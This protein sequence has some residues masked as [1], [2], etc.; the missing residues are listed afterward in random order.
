MVL[1]FFW[2]SCLNPKLFSGVNVTSVVKDGDSNSLSALQKQ[3]PGI[4]EILDFNHIIKNIPKHVNAARKEGAKGLQGRQSQI[5]A[6]VSRV[7]RMVH[8][9]EAADPAKF[10]IQIRSRILKHCGYVCAL[11]LTGDHKLC[12]VPGVGDAAPGGL[13]EQV[14]WTC[15]FAGGAGPAPESRKKK[16]Q[17]LR[18][19]KSVGFVVNYFEQ[20]ASKPS[21]LSG[22]KHM[23]YVKSLER[24]K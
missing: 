23:Y 14:D 9:S 11:H 13:L 5:Q 16:D 19:A 1:N 6:Q 18:C 20:L 4:V 3:F 15:P 22:G 12:P 21:V 2:A 17:P 8:R 7:L 10:T 24:G